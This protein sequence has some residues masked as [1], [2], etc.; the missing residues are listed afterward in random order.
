MPDVSLQIWF[1][2]AVTLAPQNTSQIL[3][4]GPD[5]AVAWTRQSGGWTCSS[6][7]SIW[8]AEG[9]T[10]TVSPKD[11]D[12][13]NAVDVG[14]FV[15]GVKGHDWQA[16]A[17]LALPKRRSLAKEGATFV[18]TMDEGTDRAQRYVVRFRRSAA[19]EKDDV[20]K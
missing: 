4:K 1:W 5:V 6:D 14:E 11:K 19:A 8:F 7:R 16:S 3:I 10:V 13:K 15:G 9:N 18:Y 17:T 20:G 12:K 2:I